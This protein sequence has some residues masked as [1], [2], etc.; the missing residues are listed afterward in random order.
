[1]REVSSEPVLT[2]TYPLAERFR[3][4]EGS[5][6]IY[7]TSPEDRSQHVA[8]WRGATTNLTFVEIC[9]ET[10]TSFK[11]VGKDGDFLL[12]SSSGLSPLFEGQAASR[13][14]LDITGLTHSVWASLLRA[15]LVARR[16]VVVVYVEPNEYSRSESPV[17]GQ[18]YD[19][20][21]RI[22]GIAPLPGFAVLSSSSSDAL[23]VPLLGF[24][25]TRLRHLIE[26]VQPAPERIYPVI[27]LPGFKTWYVFETY[28][29]NRAA[30]EETGAWQSVRY[31]SA[32]CPFSCF[33][34]LTELARESPMSSMK[35]A[36]IGTKP[37]A[38]GAVLFALTSP[39]RAELIYD[40]PIRKPGRTDGTDRLLVYHVGAIAS[41]IAAV[42]SASV[43]RSA[44]GDR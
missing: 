21:A 15:A 40:H 39:S 36:M 5:L 26:Q 43:A 41:G 24:E 16:E 33:Y 12:R 29:G 17:E 9:S 44:A 23:F 32:N 4:L 22:T 37:H 6:Y 8:S 25:G 30:L 31:A 11:V 35:I 7:G 28:A 14:Y 2:E 34:L 27:G 18:I 3:P 38:L 19:L 20:S 10:S 13:I 1:M 42:G